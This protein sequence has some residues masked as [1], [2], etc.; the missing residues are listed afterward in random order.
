MHLTALCSTMHVVTFGPDITCKLKNWN[1]VWV[2]R[3]VVL[4]EE[5]ELFYVCMVI[6]VSDAC[7]KL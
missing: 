1:L 3:I 2:E 5:V 7:C 6:Y 4:V